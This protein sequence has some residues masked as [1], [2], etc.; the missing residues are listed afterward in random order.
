MDHFALAR[1][2]KVDGGIGRQCGSREPA[3]TAAISIAQR[4]RKGPANHATTS[5]LLFPE[6]RD[7]LR[8]LRGL[9]GVRPGLQ[10]YRPRR[11][12]ELRGFAVWVREQAAQG[13]E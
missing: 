12:H 3:T 6:R 1:N 7:R 9:D 5:A 11:Q 10:M 2:S 8:D 13:A 4:G